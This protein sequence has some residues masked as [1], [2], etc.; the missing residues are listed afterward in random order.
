M[1]RK[2]YILENL[3]CANCAAKIERKLSKLPE[4][5]DVSVTF[6]TKQLRFAAEDPEAVLPKIRETIQSMEP[7]VEVVERTRSRRKAAETHNHEH[8]HHEHGEECGCGHDHHDHDHDHEEHEHHHHE[9]GEECG[10]GHD[11]HDHDHDH[12]GHEHHHHHHEHGEEC[13]CGHDHDHDHE[14]HE[15]HHHHHEHGEECGCG[16]DHHDHDHDHEEHEHHHHHHEHGEECGCGHDHHDHDH[17][18]EEHDH[19]H[20]H[21]EECGCGH[22]HHDHDHH[23][24]YHEHGEECGCGHDHHDHDHHHH[25]DHGP[26]KPQATRSHTHFQVDHHQVEGHPEGCQCEQCNSYV[27]Y[28]DVC[29]ESLAKCN[30]HMPD[31][32]LEKKV[33]ILEGIDCAN[34]AAKIE[35]KIRQMP[36]VGFASVAFATKQL[37]VSANNQAELLPKMQ[38][39]V[40]SIEDGVTIVPRQRKKLSGISNTKVYI[41]EGLD[42][43]NCA[44]KIEAKLRTLNGVDDLTITYATKQMKLSA[45]NPDQ[46]IP[47]IKETIDAME[48][49]I[50]IVPKDNK[51]IKSEEAGEKKFSFNNP[52]VSIGVGAVIFIIGEILEHV[53]NVPTIPMFA[54]FLIAYLVLGGKVLITAG[55][56]IMKGQVFDENFLMC[57]ATIGAFCIQEFPEAV[58]V[59]LFYRIGE[60]F[61]EKATEQSRTQIMEAV[62]LRPEVVNLVIGN[63]VRIIDAEEANVGDI[64]LVRP[65]DR[66]PLDGVII[67]GESRIDTSPVTGEPVPVMAKA[68]DNI[69]SGCVNTSGQLKIRVEKILEESMVTRILDSVE[70][71]AASKPNIDKFITRFARVYTPFVVLFA[72]FVAV[73]LPF[74]LPDSL[75][76]HFFVDS[77]Y[78]GTVNTIHGTSGTAS[79]Y[80]ALTFLVISCPCALVLSVPLAF[81]SGI[82]AGSKKGILFKGGIAIESL[83]NVKAIVM[84]KTGTIT[85]GNFVVQ[86]ANPAGNAMTANDLLAIS[87]SCELSSTHPIGNSIVE[88]AEEK[89]LSIERPSKVEEI[90]GHGIRAELSR[91][92]VLC[93]NRKL[94]DAQNV[95]LSVYQK[96]NFGT[97]VLVALNGKFVG[98]IVI[99]DTV[100]D[101]AKDAIAAV[102]KQGIITAMLTGD[103]QES[104]DAVAKE[105][106]IDEVHAKLLPQDKLSELKKIRENH[107]AV[108]F[109]GDGINDAPVLAG[110]DVGAAM[111]SGADAAIEAADV[112]FMNSEMKAI[113]EAVGIAKMT[114]SI[115]WQNVVFALAIKIIVMIMGLF[116]FANMWIAVFAD[117]GVSVLCLLNSIRILHRK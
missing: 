10:C 32:D 6:A 16:H 78:T 82:G 56:N 101:D 34:C 46:M 71:A 87:A 67:D 63:D 14:E 106:G 36:E 83:K 13:G 81:F 104:A 96:E 31:E 74:I 45:K 48:D 117:T 115:S 89:G 110:A 40:D 54:L 80:T 26:A 19:H 65:G 64:L 18:H 103:A 62:D 21:G 97:E 39:V 105:T 42:C 60:Y 37:R 112:V 95:D 85:K 57:I 92:V 30:C 94:M 12:E 53:G 28:C 3:D 75:N 99:S 47:M 88:A 29:G 50:T 22:D 58:G 7:D 72:L 61:E 27:E 84:D 23:H 11:H 38:A 8:H 70:N 91:G 20:E 77:A 49:G 111:G 113:P 4:L 108:M 52:L 51:V 2:V 98:N 69:V 44:A 55:K 86:K 76:W 24:H 9:H 59:M 35:A 102:K 15:H 116:G 43:A 1:Q 41:L 68:G 33:Y 73:V 17:D 5:S 79:I 66:I 109:V 90:A 93:G 100:K 107:G 114:N 25:H